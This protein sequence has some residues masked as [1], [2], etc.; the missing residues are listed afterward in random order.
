MRETPDNIV[1]SS[2]S[3]SDVFSEPKAMKIRISKEYARREEEL[4]TARGP[5]YAARTRRPP[6]EQE[7]V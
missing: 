6:R 3:A 4:K 2:I 5:P 1:A 7:A